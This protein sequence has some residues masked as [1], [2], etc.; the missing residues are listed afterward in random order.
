MGSTQENN[1]V[2]HLRASALPA[3][4]WKNGR[5][6]TKE[7][8]L[9][10]AGASFEKSDFDWRLSTAEIRN[11]GEFSVFPGYRRLLALVGGKELRLK[12]ANKCI[13]L[14]PEEVVEFSGDEAVSCELPSGP[15]FDLGLIFR[16]LCVNAKLNF[17]KFSH[18]VRS[19]ELSTQEVLLYVTSGGFAATVYPGEQQFGIQAGDVLHIGPGPTERL[20]MLA[21]GRPGDS[22]WAA[23]ISMSKSKFI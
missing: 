20:V 5:G 12:L 13:S 6:L 16:P 18:R 7:I 9:A 17:L 11:A 4:P 10:P 3:K 8:A 22:I 19:F 15:A 1:S 21:P 2:S 23:E 14:T